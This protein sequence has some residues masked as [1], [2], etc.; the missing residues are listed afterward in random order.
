MRQPQRHARRRP[1]RHGYVGLLQGAVGRLADPYTGAAISF[2]YGGASEVDIDH[3]VSLSDAWQ[4][5][6]ARWAYAKR[7][8]F[9]NDPL[10]LQPT[11]ASANRQKSDWDA[12]SWLP[13]NTSYRC[14]YVARQAA[15][16]KK[17]GVWVTAAER[18]AM[19][20]I[21]GRC[22]GEALRKPSRSRPSRQD[23]GRQG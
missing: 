10:N 2:V 11:D 21:L 4:K 23:G 17:Y 16:K 9:A 13:P 18:A 5:G 15:V 6:A 8:A 14:A 19:L 22:P 20:S 1:H 3:L 12:A 7:V